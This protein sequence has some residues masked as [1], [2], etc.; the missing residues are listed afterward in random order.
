MSRKQLRE[1]ARN[2]PTIQSH[3]TT[4]I[5]GGIL[6]GI[7]GLWLGWL[8]LHQFAGGPALPTIPIVG[9]APNNTNAPDIQ[10]P[11]LV[12]AG[13][14]LGH[15]DST[16]TLNSRQVLL[17]ASQLEPTAAAHAKVIGAKL[18]LLNYPSTS[19]PATHPNFNNVSTWLVMYQ[20][21]PLATG[22]SASSANTSYDLYVF[23]DANSGK[24]LLAVRV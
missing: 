21:I 13:I 22:D 24:E 10:I 14:T 8:L 7:G 5:V 23:L 2:A 12:A 9:F 11:P 3:V 4:G 17:L 6:L 15:T 1:T 20:K 16:P 18:V 19:T